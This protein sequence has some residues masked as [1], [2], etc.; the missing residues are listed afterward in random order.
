[1]CVPDNVT[2]EMSSTVLSL[3]LTLYLRM[4]GKDFS[5]KLLRKH[6]SLKMSIRT[7]MAVLVNPKS[8]DKEQKRMTRLMILWIDM[9]M[10]HFKLCFVI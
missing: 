9:I 7:N 10:L 6:E 3:L 8:Y 5:M 2:K 4:R 1:M